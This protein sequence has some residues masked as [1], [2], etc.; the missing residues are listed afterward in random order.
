LLV[1]D[2]IEE[3][4]I[5]PME[6]VSSLPTSLTDWPALETGS[7]LKPADFTDWPERAEAVSLLVTGLTGCPETASLLTPADFTD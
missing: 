4:I 7:L 1:V 3:L 2:F 6:T 5:D